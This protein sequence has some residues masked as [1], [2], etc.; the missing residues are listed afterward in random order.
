[1]G[2]GRTKKAGFQLLNFDTRFIESVST[3][4]Y[5]K[6]GQ[7]KMTELTDGRFR[8]EVDK[9]QPDRVLILFDG[10][11]KLVQGKHYQTTQ[12]E[13]I[14]GKPMIRAYIKL[15]GNPNRS[16]MSGEAARAQAEAYREAIY[17]T[18]NHDFFMVLKPAYN[19]AEIHQKGFLPS[20]RY[21]TY[22]ADSK[23][24]MSGVPYCS[25]NNEVWVL[26][27]PVGTRHAYDRTS[28]LVAYP[29][30][31]EWIESNGEQ[32]RS[33]YKNYNSELVAPWW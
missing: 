8:I 2:S 33:W 27:L 31:R 21:T 13:I 6:S 17:Q 25:V 4:V 26:K 19:S 7:G 9:S 22:D 23:G 10:L 18:K 1:M 30:L 3:H 32:K 11:D 12:G 28:L 15:A 14:T 20:M 29:D 16:A 24:R 5:E